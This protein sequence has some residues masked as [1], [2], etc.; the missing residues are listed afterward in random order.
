M[1]SNSGPPTSDPCRLLCRMR[2]AK[3]I[4]GMSRQT[5]LR[6]MAE[7]WFPKA[8][9]RGE[10]KGAAWWFNVSELERFADLELD[11]HALSA[12][13]APAHYRQAG[14]FRTTESGRRVRASA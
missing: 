14:Q 4:L 11:R 3:K 1:T 7:G 13:A 6:L 8:K 10:G 2:E 12:D 5:I 9:R